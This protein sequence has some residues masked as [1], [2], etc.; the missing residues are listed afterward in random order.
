MLRNERCDGNPQGIACEAGK[1]RVVLSL[2][3]LLV[4]INCITRH[5]RYCEAVPA[6]P[7][8]GYVPAAVLKTSPS[9]D[10]I[11]QIV[12][13]VLITSEILLKSLVQQVRGMLECSHAEP[14]VLM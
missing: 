1:S 2:L 10:S 5:L 3:L 4:E 9:Q 8:C 12:K 7:I 6:K 13:R 11:L 14:A